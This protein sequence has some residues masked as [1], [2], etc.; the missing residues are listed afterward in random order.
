MDWII[1]MPDVED[2]HSNRD[3]MK[4]PGIKQEVVNDGKLCPAFKPKA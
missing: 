4:S 3:A 1:E 2:P